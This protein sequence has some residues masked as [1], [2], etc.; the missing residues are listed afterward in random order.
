MKV[1]TPEEYLERLPIQAEEVPLVVEKPTF[2]AANM[3]ITA[4]KTNCIDMDDDRSALG[5]LHCM[6]DSSSME[7]GK[8]AI[9][10]SKD[11]GE[12][13]FNGVTTEEMRAVHM[14]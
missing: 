8:T 14:V 1:L 10:A 11:P 6:M 3:V 2:V 9:L 7:A 5:K 12:L 13:N 4:L